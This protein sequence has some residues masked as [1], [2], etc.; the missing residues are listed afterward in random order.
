MYPRP[1]TLKTTNESKKAENVQSKHLLLFLTHLSLVKLKGEHMRGIEIITNF[2]QKIGKSPHC[3]QIEPNL[4][5]VQNLVRS[6]QEISI[7]MMYHRLALEMFVYILIL[8]HR[9]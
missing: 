4:L 6:F 9:N 2:K 7:E 1:I 5:P 8:F 3:I